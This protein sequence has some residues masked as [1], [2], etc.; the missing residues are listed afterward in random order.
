[1]NAKQLVLALAS[2]GAVLTATAPAA[3]AATTAPQAPA[4]PQAQTAAQ[5][6]ATGDSDVRVMI[7]SRQYK[8]KST[9]KCLDSRKNPGNAA[10]RLVPCHRA[11]HRDIKHQLWVVYNDG[12][13]RPLINT[14]ICLDNYHRNIVRMAKC[15][16]SKGQVWKWTGGATGKL[17]GKRSGKCVSTYP[18]SVYFRMDPCNTGGNKRVWKR[19]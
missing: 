6:P 19:Y 7:T 3:T 4:A 1:M 16:D 17:K 14:K 13:F 18:G 8:S 12:T 10:V 5:T 15:N 9:G 11:G 2:A